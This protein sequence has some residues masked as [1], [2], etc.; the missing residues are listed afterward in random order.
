MFP[1]T[2]ETIFVILIVILV[3]IVAF[4]PKSFELLNLTARH[5]AILINMVAKVLYFKSDLRVALY[6]M[7]SV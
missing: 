7:D 6:K 1:F 3:S 5:I 2:K 4:Q